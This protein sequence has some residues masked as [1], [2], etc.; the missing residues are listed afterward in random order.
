MSRRLKLDSYSLFIVENRQNGQKLE[1]FLKNATVSTPSSPSKSPI[2]SQPIE[3]CKDSLSLVKTEIYQCN[4][5]L[6]T[7]DKKALMNKHSRVHLPQKRKAMEDFNNSGVNSKEIKI[8]DDDESDQTS[9]KKPNQVVSTPN[10]NQS[11][12][13]ECEIRFSSMKTFLHHKTH[14]CQKYKTI[15]AVVPADTQQAKPPNN[16][17]ATVIKPT[18][19][20]PDEHRATV[21]TQ[22][23]YANE[24]LSSRLESMKPMPLPLQPKRIGDVVYVPVYITNPANIKSNQLLSNEHSS[25]SSAAE[26]P[27]DLS[28][29]SDVEPHGNVAPD[30][31][32]DLSLKYKKPETVTS[33]DQPTSENINPCKFCNLN[34]CSQFALKTHKCNSIAIPSSSAHSSQNIKVLFKCKLCL[35]EPQFSTQDSYIQHLTD[36]HSSQTVI[37]RKTPK[38]QSA[39]KTPSP[40]PI[41]S[42]SQP[43]A[44]QFY[45]C[46][47]CGYRGNTIRG[48][49]QHGKLHI[50]NNEPFSIAGLTDDELN[51]C[52][53]HAARQNVNENEN[54]LFPTRSFSRYQIPL[55]DVSSSSINDEIIN[56]E[57]NKIKRIKYPASMTKSNMAVGYYCDLCDIKFQYEQNFSVHKKFY[58]KE[59]V[60]LVK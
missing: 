20:Q 58:C 18:A 38:E 49:K 43:N 52:N 10:Q 3:N 40:Q 41:T 51:I 24:S 33:K 13:T 37:M 5:C 47:T 42:A 16:G 36:Y 23:I 12:C 35:N 34:F 4:H 31:P 6:F 29:G 32:L 44:K 15:E 53:K 25:S 8:E 1:G 55:Q 17:P 28:F 60:S 21:P 57:M 26:V 54:D 9:G 30:T 39:P 2:D 46:T 59:K 48:V 14:Y 7:T 11:Y 45:V 27:L 19:K 50:S 22:N 56:N